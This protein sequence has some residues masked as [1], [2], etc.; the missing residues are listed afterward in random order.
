MRQIGNIYL[1]LLYDVIIIPIPMVIFILPHCD[2]PDDAY[3]WV[4]FRSG[5]VLVNS[6]QLV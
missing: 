2:C 6:S 1:D 5:I 3:V 4:V